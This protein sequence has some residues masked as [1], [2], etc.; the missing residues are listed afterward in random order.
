MLYMFLLCWPG[1]VAPHHG[2]SGG[3]YGTDGQVEEGVDFSGLVVHMV[4]VIIDRASQALLSKSPNSSQHTICR[5]R[6]ISWSRKTRAPL[7]SPVHSAPGLEVLAEVGSP[8]LAL[9]F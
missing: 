9:K 6:N 5:A 3:D 1:R 7:N 4:L 8:G 2:Y